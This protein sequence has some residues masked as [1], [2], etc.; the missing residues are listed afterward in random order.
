MVQNTQPIFG[1]VPRA[2]WVNVTAAN[3]A[4]DGT[5]TVDL[6]FT[7]HAT[8]GSFL[9]KITIRPKGTNAATVV[10][11]FLNNGAVPTTAANNALLEEISIAATTLSEVAAVAGVVYNVN[12]TIPAGYRIYVTLG[13]AVAGGLQITAEGMDY[14]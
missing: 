5:G 9:Q 7:A 10:R 2:S 4:K 13:T 12:K 3:V 6:L 8:D 11:V 1:K 14:A